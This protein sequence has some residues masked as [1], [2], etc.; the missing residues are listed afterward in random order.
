MI[1]EFFDGNLESRIIKLIGDFKEY[2]SLIGG[3]FNHEEN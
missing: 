1:I 3:L 2:G